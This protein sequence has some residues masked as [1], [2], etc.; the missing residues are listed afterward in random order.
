M[1]SM[2]SRGFSQTIIFGLVG[3][4]LVIAVVFSV[5][6]QKTLEEIVTITPAA[7]TT[8][9]GEV[10]LPAKV[11]S[12]PLKPSAPK[13]LKPT[14]PSGTGSMGEGAI[15]IPVVPAHEPSAPPPA[16]AV[17]PSLPPPPPSVPWSPNFQAAVRTYAEIPSENQRATL[18][19]C[20]GKFFSSIP[21]DMGAV[22]SIA[23]GNASGTASPAEYEIFTMKLKDQHNKFDFTFPDDVYVTNIVQEQG[24]SSD[25]EDSTVY[26]ALCKDVV[27]YVTHVKELSAQVYKFVTDSYCLGKTQTGP[28]AC[29]IELLTLVSKGSPIGKV[30][31]TE[32]AFGFGVMDLRKSR[33]LSNPAQ[34]QHPVRMEFA[35][36][37]FAYFSDTTSFVSKLA[38]GD[39]L[40]SAY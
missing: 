16:A 19:S 32:G 24:I 33:G 36:C 31:M 17:E 14:A 26:F 2:T 18:P 4:V 40:C 37:P 28:N 39:P 21:I 27:G 20:D 25:S 23:A 12:A 29:H 30:G 3:L 9:G 8:P 38:S 34:Y 5:G 6:R 11:T 15:T 1:A 7:T 13:P 35:A 10:I 22:A